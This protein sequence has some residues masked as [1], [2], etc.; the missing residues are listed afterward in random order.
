MH[1]ETVARPY[2]LT[3]TATDTAYPLTRDDADRLIAAY[4]VVKAT[5]NRV[6]LRADDG[7]HCIISP[8]TLGGGPAFIVNR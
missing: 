2:T 4:P 8:A 6:T 7:H 1:V 3:F 5:C